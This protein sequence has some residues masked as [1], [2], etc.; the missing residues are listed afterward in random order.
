VTADAGLIYRGAA[1]VPW[2]VI[3][4]VT[5]PSVAGQFSNAQLANGLSLCF[6]GMTSDNRNCGAVVRANQWLCCDAT[7]RSFHFTCIN[8]PSGPGDSGGPVYRVFSG[9]RAAAAGLVSS[10]VTINGARLTCFTSI[11]NITRRLGVRLV[12]V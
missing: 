2:P 3:H 7:G 9:N 5:H 11:E 1:W 8:Y 10:S 12:V 4:S 6:E